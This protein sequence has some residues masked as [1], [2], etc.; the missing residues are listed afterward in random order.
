MG[1]IIIPFYLFALL[2]FLMSCSHIDEDER[3]VY[4][5]PAQVVRCVLLEDFTGQ[6]CVNCPKASEEIQKLT[7]QYGEDAVVAVGIHSGPLGFRTNSRFVGLSTDAGDAYF[8][9]WQLDFQPVGLIDRNGPVEYPAWGTRIREEL[10]KPAPVAIVAEAWSVSDTLAVS[11]A[12]TATDGNTAG[13]LQ[14]WVV[15]DSVTAFQL[16]PDGTRNDTYLHQHVLRA[17][18][19]GVWGEDVRVDEGNT[20][21]TNCRMPMDADWNREHLSVVAFVYDETGVLQV[22]KTHPQPLP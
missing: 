9:H 18:I 8:D 21:R 2:P 20:F 3:L 11:V 7:A 15:E 4:V 12:V 1:V 19:N 13:R 5:K 14:L 10:Q 22:T 17:A 16:M 6:R